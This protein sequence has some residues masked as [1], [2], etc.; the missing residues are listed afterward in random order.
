ML[1]FD[2][3]VQRVFV[4]KHAHLLELQQQAHLNDQKVC[5]ACYYCYSLLLGLRRCVVKVLLII[6]IEMEFAVALCCQQIAE[7][8]TA[9]AGRMRLE[10]D[11]KVKVIKNLQQDNSSKL[12]GK[13]MAKS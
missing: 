4:V 13:T 3:D 9:F 2:I 6:I 5:A 12:D 11:E 1:N 7:M 8:E 10:H